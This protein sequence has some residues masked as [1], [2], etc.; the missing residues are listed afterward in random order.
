MR[1]LAEVVYTLHKCLEGAMPEEVVYTIDEA[2][3]LLKVSD[4]TIRRMIAEGTLEA[5]KVRGQWR[6]KKASLDKLLKGQR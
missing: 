6:I 5:V 4:D 1:K 3:K 2:K